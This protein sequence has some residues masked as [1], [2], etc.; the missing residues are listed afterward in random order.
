VRLDQR[1]QLALVGFAA[2]PDGGR[3]LGQVLVMGQHLADA[4]S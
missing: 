1:T 3:D 4:L 2:V